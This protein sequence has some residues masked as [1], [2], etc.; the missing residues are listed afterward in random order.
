MKILFFK[1]VKRK[2][3]GDNFFGRI[4]LLLLIVSFF[5]M[6]GKTGYF[7]DYR[8]GNS[9][10]PLKEQLVK[11]GPYSFSLVRARNGDVV[12]FKNHDKSVEYHEKLINFDN[13][14]YVLNIYKNNGGVSSVYLWTYSGNPMRNIWK[15]DIGE[16]EVM[17]YERSLFVYRED[18]SPIIPFEL[19][20]IFFILF[21]VFSYKFVAK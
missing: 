10:I 5:T 21:I 17:S 13:K 4:F 14:N 15:I 11:S 12:E 2:Y 18:I 19:I 6:F 20:I 3:I 8:L 16:K 1:I 7:L 9:V